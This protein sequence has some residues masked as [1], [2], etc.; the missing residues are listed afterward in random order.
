[1]MIDDM[2]KDQKYI[3]DFG[4]S[5][6]QK[7]PELCSLPAFM[8]KRLHRV[9]WFK[10]RFDSDGLPGWVAVLKCVNC[11]REFGTAFYPAKK[12]VNNEP[13]IQA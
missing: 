6:P 12:E 8:D 7:T 13:I 11:G 4:Y 10:D 2:A 9:G 1:M 3:P 5:S